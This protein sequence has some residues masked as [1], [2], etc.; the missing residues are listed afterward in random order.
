MSKV[1]RIYTGILL[2]VLLLKHKLRWVDDPEWLPEVMT[3]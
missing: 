3:R 2:A 1:V